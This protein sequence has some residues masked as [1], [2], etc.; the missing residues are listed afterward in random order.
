[1]VLEIKTAGSKPFA[2]LVKNGVELEKPEHFAQMQLYMRGTGMVKALYL[3]VC[4]DTD[5]IHTE[6]IDFDQV[7]ANAAIAKARRVLESSQPPAK[8]SDHPSWWKC[9]F[10]DHRPHCQ[11]EQAPE[12]SCRTCVHATPE[13]DE[14]RAGLWTCSKLE[15]GLTLAKQRV[16]CVEHLYIPGMINFAE[17]IDADERAGWVEYK[18]EQGVFFKNSGEEYAS[19]SD[20][21]DAAAPPWSSPDIHAL[22][23]KVLTDDPLLESI[24][25]NFSPTK[26]EN[27]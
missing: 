15:K 2:K 21:Q 10:C 23:A 27:D 1:M 19:L 7:A 14:N 11:G 9:K 18:S 22:G 20:K 4:K 26:L 13:I 25:R 16:G 17:A 6:V 24:R 5:S 8:I 12:V 3:A